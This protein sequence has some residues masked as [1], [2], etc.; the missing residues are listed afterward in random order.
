MT[1]RQ[2]SSTIQAMIDKHG[3]YQALKT[4]GPASPD[5]NLRMIYDLRTLE[6]VETFNREMRV[7]TKTDETAFQARLNELNTD[8][9][10]VKA[11]TS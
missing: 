3:P 8:Y 4:L 5:R 6:D 7:W 10:R 1:E 11:A 2:V 9:F